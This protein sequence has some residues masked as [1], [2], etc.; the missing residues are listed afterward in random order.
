MAA[1]DRIDVHQ[2]IVP[3]FWAEALRDHGGDPSGWHSPAWSPES[4]LS[5]M[6]RQGIATGILSLTA[7]G[8]SGWS[9][10]ARRDMARRVN[11]HTADL[12]RRHP[13]RF[14]LFATLPMPDVDGALQE[15]A[16]AFDALQ[17]DGVILLSNYDGRYLG[18]PQFE[19]LWSELNRRRAVVFVH[20]A[21][22]PLPVLD[23]IPGPI[24]D[25]P[26]D[27]TRAAVQM[28]V[29]G[30]MDRYPDLRVILSHA[31]GFLP[32]ASHRFAEVAAVARPEMSAHS[33][34]DSFRRFHFDTAL[35]A[36]PAALPSL[37]AFAG[38][39]R[40]LYGSDFPYAP[41]VVSAG[42]TAM[43]DAHEGFSPADLAAVNRQNAL[44]LFKRLD[45][46]VPCP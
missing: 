39:G 28:A 19:P 20:P 24:V 36:S 34:L 44:S 4:A 35:S 45:A 8:V 26:F 40:I 32:F 33:I 37:I 42:F 46:S 5:F 41:A 10:T 29:N 38:T 13:D 25:Y 2:H 14:G 22:P 23:G 18:A 21:K 11:D 7:P 31:G 30:V 12:V 15:T 17:A 9:G 16:H 6:D 3:P 27:T 43:L 1:P